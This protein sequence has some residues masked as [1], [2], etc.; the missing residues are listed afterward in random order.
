MASP[1]LFR[2]K[3]LNLNDFLQL[4][5]LLD[6]EQQE[7]DRHIAACQRKQEYCPPR[8]ANPSYAV[9]IFRQ[10]SIDDAA[11]RQ[12][13]AEK[14]RLEQAIFKLKYLKDQYRR[15]RNAEIQSY[16]DAY[17]RQA[18]IRAVQQEEEERYY[19]QCIAAALE[20]QRVNALWQQYLK[21]KREEDDEDEGYSKY[22]TQQLEEL[23]RHVFAHHPQYF[24]EGAEERAPSRS[25]QHHDEETH[26]LAT[27]EIWKYLSDQKNDSQVPHT[28]A[29]SSD[30][31]ETMAP[32]DTNTSNQH[33][34]EHE[35]DNESDGQSDQESERQEEE[36]SEATSRASSPLPAV[37]EHV[38]NLQDLIQK[39][40]SEPVLAHLPVASE[41]PQDT[42]PS[43]YSDEPKPSGIWYQSQPP[44]ETKDK[45]DHEEKDASYL[46]QH[47]FT[48]AEPTPTHE[49]TPDAP[50]DK[51]TVIQVNE[52][53]AK[54]TKEESDF[55]DSVAAEQKKQDVDPKKT[56]QMESLD[57][58]ARELEEDSDLVKRWKQVLRSK[59][60]F[61]KQPE[62]TLLVT[63]S[64]DANRK[65]LGSEDEIT[66]LMLKLDAVDSMGDEEIREK[67]R[68]LVKK[69]EHMVDVLDRMKHLQ[70][71]NAFKKLE[72]KK[73]NNRRRKNKKNKYKR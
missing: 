71:E 65:Y 57:A 26:D 18:L 73:K 56:K 52:E 59:L 46:P 39:L 16:L 23:L 29:F 47:V 60:N 64:T 15:Q 67:R 70:W 27:D 31:K 42:P 41:K 40:A 8:H 9:P 3:S 2:N 51:D 62:G 66:R 12:S 35:S 21:A 4:Q 50:F 11:E 17:R 5:A 10:R 36:S 1:F 55:V 6:Y 54:K 58:I 38:V 72:K 34:I 37:Q 20:Q 45:E 7:R 32:S 44:S 49:K 28:A 30:Q 69:C 19:R 48:E 13:L 24:E 25:R 33:E 63:A 14:Q 22:R 53:E 43:F 68:T 61:T